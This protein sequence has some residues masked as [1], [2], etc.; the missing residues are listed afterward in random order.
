MGFKG[1]LKIVKNNLLL[2]V[3]ILKKMKKKTFR[4]NKGVVLHLEYLGEYFVNSHLIESIFMKSVYFQLRRFPFGE[5]TANELLKLQGG[6]P[7]FC[8]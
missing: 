3:L 6:G 4:K 8:R 1:D 5:K 7:A 2:R